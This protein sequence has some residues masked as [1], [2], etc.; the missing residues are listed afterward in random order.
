MR[1]PST[2]AGLLLLALCAVPGC[3]SAPPPAPPGPG[4]EAQALLDEP[5]LSPAQA[6]LRGAV[7]RIPI[8]RSY[9]AA[10]QRGGSGFMQDGSMRLS[11]LGARIGA[12][13]GNDTITDAF[14]RM[15]S[16]GGDTS[17]RTAAE[18]PAAPAQAAGLRPDLA[19]A[20]AALMEGAARAAET[21]AAEARAA[22]A[23]AARRAGG[24]A[25]RR[26]AP[27]AAGGRAESLR[28]DA[29]AMELLA[30]DAHRAAQRAAEAASSLP[31]DSPEFRAYAQRLLRA[32]ETLNRARAE[33]TRTAG[34]GG[35]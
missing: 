3:E 25:R 30:T 11:L 5:G 34:G 32:E 22:A 27:E 7:G 20:D 33:V 23:Q 28:R 18:A 10:A 19:E 6:T 24:G 17:G 1:A 35:G 13:L 21:L 16:R 12:A 2:P 29:R 26:D 15:G 9:I 31:N 4:P 14:T 8:E